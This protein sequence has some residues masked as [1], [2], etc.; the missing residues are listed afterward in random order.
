MR[1]KE[2]IEATIKTL[3]KLNGLDHVNLT[4]LRKEYGEHFAAVFDELRDFR[5]VCSPDNDGLVH[6]N[7]N[8]L[9]SALAHYKAILGDYD[10][11]SWS[12]R[13]SW[14]ALIVSIIAL[15]VSV[16]KEL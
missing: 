12:D 15:I 9:A 8:Y 4:N 3:E 1:S 14:I 11:A 7:Q 16:L 5:V 13:R 10:R 2:Q 6:I